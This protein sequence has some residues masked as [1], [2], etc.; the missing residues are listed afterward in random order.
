MMKKKERRGV[1]ETAGPSNRHTPQGERKGLE[2]GKWASDEAKKAQS[3][4]MIRN[5]PNP[6]TNH[7]YST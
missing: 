3:K 4:K 2:K 1:S 7:H 5:S 6:T